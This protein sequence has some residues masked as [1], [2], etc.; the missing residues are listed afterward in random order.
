MDLVK[1]IQTLKPLLK[2][3]RKVAKHLG[4][5]RETVAKYWNPKVAGTNEIVIKTSWDKSIDWDYVSQESCNRGVSIKTLYKEFAAFNELPAYANFARYYRLNIKKDEAPNVS[6]R[7]ERHPGKTLEIDYSGDKMEFIIPS[8]G[9]VIEAN[10][11]V[12]AMSYSGFFY[13]EFTLSQKLADFVS[14]CKNAFEYIGGVPQFLVSDNCLTAVTKAEK[15]DFYLNKGFSDFCRHY[16]VIADPA[17]I[18]RPKDK[19]NVENAIGVIQKEFFQKYRNFTFTSLHE[20]NVT[21]RKYIDEKMNESNGK[22]SRRELLKLEIPLLKPLPANPF[23]LFN[24]K[25]CKVHPD[26]H[27]RYASNFYSVPHIY[28]GKEVEIK[29]NTKMIYIFFNAEEVAV[30]QINAGHAHYSTQ[31][32]HYPDKKLL[33]TNYHIQSSKQKSAEIGPFTEALINKLFDIPRNHPLRNLSKVQGILALKNS[34][35]VEALEYA[36][37]AALESNKLNYMYVKSC[38]KNYKGSIKENLLPSRRH[39]FICLQGG[40]WN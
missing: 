9:E 34:F 10:L 36:S 29:F 25:V 1:E 35:S 30:H 16:G 40:L 12:A 17:R 32:G 2:H 8:T 24:Y 11:F 28:V 14:A 22:L 6:L 20:L 37:E 18:W 31:N 23:E 26:C 4:I 7:I 21:L 13:A 3:K 27:I 19:P 15:H 39:E 5:D 33:D 38:A